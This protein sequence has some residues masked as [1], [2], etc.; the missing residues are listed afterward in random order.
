M[1]PRPQLI[2]LT[3]ACAVMLSWTSRDTLA[4]D[5]TSTDATRSAARAPPPKLRELN[6]KQCARHDAPNLSK[7]AQRYEHRQQQARE[8][9]LRARGLTTLALPADDREL[10]R[11]MEWPADAKARISAA[12]KAG[13]IPGPITWAHQAEH[14]TWT[15]VKD[16]KGRV[17]RLIDAP[18]TAQIDRLQL[19]SC[20]PNPQPSHECRVST[21][22]PACG[23]TSL[24]LFGPLPEGM[25]YQGELRLT[26]PI[27]ELLIEPSCAP[28]ATSA[29]RQPC[30]NA[31]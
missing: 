5:S 21:G 4:Q 2:A 10:W 13:Y 9:A 19:C 18:Y 24:R 25:S 23:S 7:R 29:V 8:A 27:T 20:L 6:A 30:H 14:E 3:I 12:S 1:S 17:Y 16:A 11:G 26:Y 15:F 28:S 22:C 31:P